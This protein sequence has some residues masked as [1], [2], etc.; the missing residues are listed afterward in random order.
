MVA[1]LQDS[2]PEQLLLFVQSFGIPVHSMNRL[3]QRLDTEVT[4]NVTSL[5]ECVR[6]KAYMAQVIEVQHDRGARGGEKFYS[7]LTNGGQL[8]K[9]K[10]KSTL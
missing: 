2:P 7:M 1:A 8:G 9:T 5:E 10:G 6:D 4:V 3:L